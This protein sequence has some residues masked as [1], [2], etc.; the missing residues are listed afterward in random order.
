MKAIFW[1]RDNMLVA[2]LMCLASA[3]TAAIYQAG[4]VDARAYKLLAD[5]WPRMSA[6]MKAKVAEAMGDG[7]ITHWEYTALFRALMDDTHGFAIDNDAGDVDQEK[8]K[9]QQQVGRGPAG[10]E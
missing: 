10:K 8:A 5:Q 9:L 1:V 7:K 6:P 4:Q 2:L 3:S